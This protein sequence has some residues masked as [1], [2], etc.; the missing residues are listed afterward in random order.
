MVLVNIYSFCVKSLG[1]VI[2]VKEAF[3][4]TWSYN[5]IEW[6]KR[7]ASGFTV[8]F[9]TQKINSWFGVYSEWLVGGASTL[10]IDSLSDC[11]STKITTPSEGIVAP[12]LLPSN[13]A[14][15]F[16]LPA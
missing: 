2:G 6:E 16:L 9:L 13:P 8:E 10:F 1:E 7:K 5:A 12:P 3:T 11:T 15:I 4:Q 14:R